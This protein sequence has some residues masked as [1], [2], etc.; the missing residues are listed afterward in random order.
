MCPG[1]EEQRLKRLWNAYT[2]NHA[3]S[4]AL[5]LG[6]IQ[7]DGYPVGYTDW[8]DFVVDVM[9]AM[10]LDDGGQFPDEWFDALEAAETVRV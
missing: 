6:D 5:L 7:K 1:E 9:E 8:K 4:L 10:E 3:E 2:S